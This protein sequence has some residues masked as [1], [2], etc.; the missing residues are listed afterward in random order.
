MHSLPFNDN[1]FLILHWLDRAKAIA[2][3]IPMMAIRGISILLQFFL[4]LVIAR[5][6]GTAGVAMVQ[7]Y[8]SWVSVL[9]ETNCL[10]LANKATKFTALAD[11][12]AN[13]K[14]QLVTCSL[15][16][17]FIWLVASLLL[18]LGLSTKLLSRGELN[19]VVITCLAVSVL[20]F[21]ILRLVS[22]ALKALNKVNTAIMLENILAT[23]IVLAV[24]AVG[25]SQG[26]LSTTI[27]AEMIIVVLTIALTLATSICLFY[28][29][30]ALRCEQAQLVTLHNSS[31]GQRIR[32][33]CNKETVFFWGTS[34]LSIIFLN[35]PFLL[36]SNSA[37]LHQVGLFA[38]AY[39]CVT[40]ITTILLMLGAVFAP[41]FAIAGN[42]LNSKE[43]LANLRQTQ[44]ASLIFYLPVVS[45]LIFFPDQ[46]LNLFGKEFID[47]KKFLFLLIG[48]QLI[49]AL[50]GLPGV[51]LNMIGKSHIEFIGTAIFC[52]MM[53]VVGY[54]SGEAYGLF[55]LAICYGLAVSAKNIWSYYWAIRIINQI[56][57]AAKKHRDNYEKA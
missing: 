9:G 43:L 17:I 5:L 41:K 54:I 20:C 33:L 50:T 27:T 4:Q 12:Y 46:V 42:D 1:K 21:A 45:I 14:Q 47:A 38:I 36:A 48:A 13:I 57:N 37:D 39:K 51:M 34:V 52:L 11:T 19:I 22:S 6:T 30:A 49:N 2:E 8:Q 15:I 16:I 23:I 18:V 26:Y 56:S 55:G 24:L 25:F 10:G 3:L 40:P 28:C 44:I 7:V 29:W 31:W 53:L 32:Q 35:A